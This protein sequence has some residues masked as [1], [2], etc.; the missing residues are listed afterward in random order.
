MKR[1]GTSCSS[2]CLAGRR[3]VAVL[4]A[5]V[6][7]CIAF[8][9]DVDR[10]SDELKTEKGQKDAVRALYRIAR[11]KDPFL[12]VKA[13]V[14]LGTVWRKVEPKKVARLTREYS[15]Q[16]NETL[17]YPR[18]EGH[19]EYIRL[20][21]REDLGQALLLLNRAE[22][23]CSGLPKVVTIE[24]MGDCI[25]Q[26]R[27]WQP[28]LQVYQRALDLGSKH[29]K[30]EKISKAGD[31]R[32]PAKPNAEYWPYVKNRILDKM[33]EV[34][35][36]IRCQEYGMDFA[37]YEWARDAHKKGDLR[38][39]LRIYDL[40]D[41][42]HSKSTFAEAARYYRC[43]CIKN[44]KDPQATIKELEAFCKTQ[45][46]G[47]YRGEAHFKIGETYLTKLWDRSKAEQ[48][49]RTAIS[50]CQDVRRSK[51]AVKL[52]VNSKK[53]IAI[54]APPAEHRKVDQFNIISDVPIH[55]QKLVNRQ[56]A[57][58]YINNIERLARY[59][60]V[61]CL[62]VDNKWAEAR[63]TLAPVLDLDPY[64]RDVHSRKRVSAYYRYQMCCRY[65]MLSNERDWYVGFEK[66]Y[67]LKLMY[68][69][70]LF[71]QRRFYESKQLLVKLLKE[72]E[73]QR[74][75]RSIPL[76]LLTLASST[77]MANNPG[78]STKTSFKRREEEETKILNRIITEYP[79]HILAACAHRRLGLT[80]ARRSGNVESVTR[81]L[82]HFKQAV[83]IWPDS[84]TAKSA[85]VG[86]MGALLSLK[87]IDEARAVEKKLVLI[88]KNFEGSVDDSLEAD[89]R[90]EEFIKKHVRQSN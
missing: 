10:W 72:A 79:R 43:F 64:L 77:Q 18:I 47:L 66:K 71:L 16:S 73:K 50:W 9:D 63:S 60:L 56:T 24:G 58:W 82:N 19:V 45:P 33:Q 32:E 25:R 80:Y 37:L 35:F 5:C 14:A 78:E 87:R 44:G 46:Y 48:A 7:S 85:M 90:T 84:E 51:R 15:E 20:K 83:R 76:I 8:S 4:F 42:E 88:D 28:A 68:A 3:T 31:E 21:A 40:L 74:S 22:E 49:F 36:E 17:E 29:F 69:E 62:F 34:W 30:R 39:A 38:E 57:P 13:I 86:M 6:I 11:S 61:F 23:K 75:K 81:G 52:Y 27:K 1:P 53:S 2:F 67:R 89:R 59:G 12:S 41:D 65:Q 55:S 26:Q 54:S 70:F